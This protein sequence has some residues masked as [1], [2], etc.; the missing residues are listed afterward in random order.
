MSEFGRSVERKS[1]VNCQRGK[2][3]LV[4]RL[5][6]HAVVLSVCCMVVGS[7]RAASLLTQQTVAV[8]E[9][10]VSFHLKIEPSEMI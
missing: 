2:H 4:R 10:R 3:E 7:L 9:Y 5:H 6:R 1:P 8:K